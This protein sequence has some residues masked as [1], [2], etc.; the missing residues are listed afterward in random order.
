[1]TLVASEV[2][3]WPQVESWLPELGFAA[4]NTGPDPYGRDTMTGV[5]SNIN[6]QNHAAY[7][8]YNGWS[9]NLWSQVVADRQ[10]SAAHQ[11][12]Q[13]GPLLTG[14]QWVTNPYSGQQV[15]VSTTPAV[16]WVNRQGQQLPSHDPSFDPRTPMD[17]DW[18]RLR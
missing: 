8:A 13:M 17:S 18:Q 5:I 2:N 16:I 11:A 1:M 15:Q 7:V 14:K 10:N 12:G 9:Q 4:F 6:N 3:M